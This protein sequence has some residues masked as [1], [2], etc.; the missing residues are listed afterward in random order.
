MGACAAFNEICEIVYRAMDPNYIRDEPEEN[1]YENDYV[2]DHRTFVERMK[3]IEE[4]KS[5]D[6]L[7]ANENTIA[8]MKINGLTKIVKNKEIIKNKMFQTMMEHVSKELIMKYAAKTVYFHENE[9]VAIFGSTYKGSSNEYDGPFDGP[10]GGNIPKTYSR[11]SSFVSIEV[12]NFMKSYLQFFDQPRK[13][14]STPNK[15]ME[16]ELCT[17]F[18]KFDKLDDKFF[19]F[20][21]QNVKLIYVDTS[22]VQVDDSDVVNYILFKSM[23]TKHN[24][25]KELYKCSVQNYDMKLHINDVVKQLE[26]NKIKFEESLTN[27]D[28]Y[29][30]YVKREKY[31]INVD[32]SKL[33]VYKHHC[34]KDDP[35]DFPTYE[36]VRPILLNLN[37]EKYEEHLE[38]I[39]N[40]KYYY[41]EGELS[42]NQ[43]SS[44]PSSD[45][46]LISSVVGSEKPVNHYV[47]KSITDILEQIKY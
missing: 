12:F 14:R 19:E 28:M 32:E 39:L 33:D 13:T 3:E 1:D 34:K 17:L 41:Y 21:L 36:R 18:E 20:C 5:N 31:D 15:T 37:I 43:N 23:Y 7:Y 29:G 46:E 4:D 22:L 45:E 35:Q 2:N 30:T 8:C 42:S 38:L 10:F 24:A 26:L 25:V 27:Y 6:Y 16:N 11:L 40:S 47:D 44:E 9:L